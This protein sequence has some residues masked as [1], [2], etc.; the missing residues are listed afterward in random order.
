MKQLGVE[1]SIV[2]FRTTL[3]KLILDNNPIIRD[4]IIDKLD[5]ILLYL[6][7]PASSPNK[8]LCISKDIFISVI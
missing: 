3:R 2:I 4:K 1:R 5:E 7:I 8:K 6:F